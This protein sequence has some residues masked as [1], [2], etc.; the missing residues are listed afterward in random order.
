MK[1]I[2]GKTA[3]LVVGIL[4][5]FI[6]VGCQ[7]RAWYED[8]AVSRARTFVE[9]KCRY[10]SQQELEFVRYH[11]PVVMTDYII[12][13]N[14]NRLGKRMPLSQ[15]CIAWMIPNRQEALVVFG[16]GSGD[17]NDWYPNRVFWK[18]YEKPNKILIETRD[19]VAVYAINNMLFMNRKQVNRVRFTVPQ[20]VFT[21]FDLS[22]G[23]IPFEDRADARQKLLAAG[24][25]GNV[26]SAKAAK[27]DL[28]Q[29]SFFWIDPADV[30]SRIVVTGLCKQNNLTGFSPATASFMNADDLLK[31]TINKPGKI[32][33]ENTGKNAIK[34]EMKVQTAGNT[35]KKR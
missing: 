24:A 35:I 26:K 2:S 1:F 6:T 34:A 33:M 9:E 15:I 22:K 20:Q 21:N 13:F 28:I 16:W 8:R 31:H 11:K 23:K 10:L 29:V 7:S 27:K 14:A 17:F 4:M 18:R 19:K 5:L 30:D 12:G 25:G 3:F 32:A